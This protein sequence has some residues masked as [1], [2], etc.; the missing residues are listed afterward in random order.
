MQLFLSYESKGFLIDSRKLLNYEK[1][2]QKELLIRRSV[3]MPEKTIEERDSSMNSIN[4]KN[5]IL[6]KS[7][8]LLS[9][10]VIISDEENK[11]KMRSIVDYLRSKTSN[12]FRRRITILTIN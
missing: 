8:R 7:I 11:N 1:N 6:V 10:Q 4:E 9:N 5:K 3:R 12:M 2:S